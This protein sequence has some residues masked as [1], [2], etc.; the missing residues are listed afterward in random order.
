MKLA[1][2]KA[3]PAENLSWK[4]G[5]LE[6]NFYHPFLSVTGVHGEEGAEYWSIGVL[7]CWRTCSPEA[8]WSVGEMSSPGANGLVVIGKG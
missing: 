7:E 8:N 1:M 4:E 5:G 2:P 3:G 6:K